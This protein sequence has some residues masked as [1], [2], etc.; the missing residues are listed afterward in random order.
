MVFILAVFIVLLIAGLVVDE[1]SVEQAILFVIALL[2]C[3]LVVRFFHLHMLWLM[4]AMVL[5]NA[6][7]V[8]KVIGYDPPIRPGRRLR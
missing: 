7:L 5:I 6:V 1:L 3:Y 4:A 8:L 2:S